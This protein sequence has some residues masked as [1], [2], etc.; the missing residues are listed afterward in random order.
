MSRKFAGDK[1]VKHA[2]ITNN[3]DYQNQVMLYNV[4]SNVIMRDP[5]SLDP[6]VRAGISRASNLVNAEST[7]L[8]QPIMQKAEELFQNDPTLSRTSF[9]EVQKLLNAPINK[10]DSE[11]S[12]IRGWKNADVH[13]GVSVGSVSNILSAIPYENWGDVLY[14]AGRKLPITSQAYSGLMALSKAAHNAAHYDP[15][16]QQFYKGE[17]TRNAQIVLPGTTQD[18]AVYQTID[19]LRPQLLMS[20]YAREKDIRFLNE[21]AMRLND[22][23]GLNIST[24]DLTSSMYEPT[25]RGATRAQ[26]L[27]SYSDPSRLNAATRA[28][29]NTTNAVEGAINLIGKENVRSARE[30]KDARNAAARKQRATGVSN[31]VTMPTVVNRPGTNEKLSQLGLNPQQ[32]A[33]ARLL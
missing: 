19:Q 17:G 22:D 1:A 5:R 12:L 18:D 30:A 28:A 23:T 27:N 31:A 20:G 10:T 8:F 25:R 29:Y 21:L 9:K 26:Y 16:T 11:M 33:A 3:P 24:K 6:R 2:L 15:I 14:E 4:L 13:H 32:L 7:A